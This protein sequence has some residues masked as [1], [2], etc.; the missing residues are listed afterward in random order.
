VY[1]R[2]RN[3]RFRARNIHF[4]AANNKT[5][6]EKKHLLGRLETKAGLSGKKIR[7]DKKLE[8]DWHRM[9]VGSFCRL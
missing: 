7:E 4:R 3:I 6:E 1:F 8:M 5:N 9:D 2:P